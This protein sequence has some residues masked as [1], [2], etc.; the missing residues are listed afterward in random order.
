MIILYIALA[1]LGLLI[2]AR[3]AECWDKR[4]TPLCLVIFLK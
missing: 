4:C 3:L 2:W 1:A